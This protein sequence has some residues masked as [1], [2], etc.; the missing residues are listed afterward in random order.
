M[1]TAIIAEDLKNLWDR[2]GITFDSFKYITQERGNE[3]IEKFPKKFLKAPSASDLEQKQ[4]R[5][6]KSKSPG[7]AR[8]AKTKGIEPNEWAEILHL[9]KTQEIMT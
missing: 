8:G 7:L 4:G 2:P 1:A 9:N 5:R 6:S 3:L